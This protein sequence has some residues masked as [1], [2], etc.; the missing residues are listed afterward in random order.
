MC[1]ELELRLI[2][3]SLVDGSPRVGLVRSAAPERL[4]F[5]PLSR[6]TL[7]EKVLALF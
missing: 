6:G 3:L 4:R 2:L 7:I 1:L 5:L